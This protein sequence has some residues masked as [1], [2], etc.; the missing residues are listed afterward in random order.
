MESSIFNI[1]LGQTFFCFIIGACVMVVYL[2]CA[3]LRP[4]GPHVLITEWASSTSL[5][6]GTE[7]TEIGRGNQPRSREI[8]EETEVAEGDD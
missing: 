7:L 2:C 3:C 4:R 6:S 5:V 1:I 8:S